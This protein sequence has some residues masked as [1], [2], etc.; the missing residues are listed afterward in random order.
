MRRE[1]ESSLL[2]L[3]KHMYSVTCTQELSF[4]QITSSKLGPCI[5][6]LLSRCILFFFFDTLVQSKLS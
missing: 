6:D 2:F 5:K 1:L 3:C 4:A